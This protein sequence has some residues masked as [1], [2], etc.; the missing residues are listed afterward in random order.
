MKK[1]GLKP[2][3]FAGT[4]IMDDYETIVIFAKLTRFWS[5]WQSPKGVSLDT[6]VGIR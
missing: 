3:D 5:R 6:G 2:S 4:F 1:K